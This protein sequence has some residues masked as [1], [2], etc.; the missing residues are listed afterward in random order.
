MGNDTHN[1]T[2]R[3]TEQEF[4]ELK[5]LSE[6]YRVSRATVVQ[7]AIEALEEHIRRNKGKVALPLDFRD[8]ISQEPALVSEPAPTYTTKK[9]KTQSA[10]ET[11]VK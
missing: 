5:T 3:L 6:R 10:D 9:A 8:I 7:W 11:S 2:V 4:T 1:I